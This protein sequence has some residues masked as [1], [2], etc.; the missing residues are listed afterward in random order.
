MGASKNK[1]NFSK[2]QKKQLT[3]IFLGVIFLTAFGFGAFYGGRALG[4]W[5]ATTT[6]TTT[7]TSEDFIFYV[8]DLRLGTEM[9]DDDHNI[10]LWRV[11]ITEMD[12]EEIDDLTFA[13]YSLIESS[14]DS[15][16]DYNDVDY[17]E[18][19]Y[20]CKLNGSDIVEYWFIPTDGLLDVTGA[21][22]HLYATNMTEDLAFG[23][24]SVDERETQFNSNT[25][26]LNYDEWYFEYLCLD[27]VE[28]TGDK[29]NTQGYMP[30]YDFEDDEWKT[31]LL[32]IDW[33]VTAELSFCELETDYEYT[34]KVAGTQTI[35]EIKAG[36]FGEGHFKI[37]IGSAYGT[38]FE[39]M[40]ST[41]A[42]GT[43]ESYTTWDTYTN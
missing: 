29:T 1:L 20:Y 3:T 8:E 7:L 5:G 35:Y 27:D 24:I 28:G 26:G 43:A 40:N 21:N 13:D 39:S 12:D 34:E 42:Y 15:G 2:K 30:Y 17:E 6:T 22:N 41:M 16:D 9:D 4:W 25:S 37:D 18:Y 14:L 33:N 38:D 36:I 11:D 23:M 32:I 10:Y 19:L 31:V